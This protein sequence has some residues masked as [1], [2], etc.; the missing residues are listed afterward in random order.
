M[1]PG[2]E[3]AE[4]PADAVE[5]GHIL[6]AWGVAGWFKILPY[7]ADPDALLSSKCWLLLPARDR[8]KSSSSAARLPIR[9]VKVHSGSM[10][11]AACGLDDREAAQALQGARIFISR[12]DFPITRA[13]EYYWV[14][15]IGLDVVNRDNVALGKVRELLSTG[16]QTV[17]LMD[18]LHEGKTLERMIPFVSIYVDEVDIAARRIVV[19]W[20]ADYLA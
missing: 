9:Q 12:S 6:G 5:V 19:D 3:A 4:L 8:T 20:Q 14:D 15:L 17:L 18:Y 1:W 16:A 7:S 2:L 11:A 13:N 10:V